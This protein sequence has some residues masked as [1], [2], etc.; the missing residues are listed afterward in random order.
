MARRRMLDPNF[1]D[2]EDVCSLPDTER[3][4]LVCCISNADDEGKLSGSAATIK[5]IAFG[6]TDTTIQEV[7]QMLQHISKVIR[8]FCR[9]EVE[10]KTYIK[11]LHWSKYQRVD[12][13]YAS[14]IPDPNESNSKNDSE[15]DSE[16][17]SENGSKNQTH[18]LINKVI[19]NELSN[20]GETQAKIVMLPTDFELWY[21]AYP[22]KVAKEAASKA[23][24]KQKKIMPTL[25][26]MLKALDRQKLS[27]EWLNNGGKFIPYPATYLN[28]GRWADEVQ[29]ANIE[30]PD[31]MPGGKNRPRI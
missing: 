22:K 28:Q 16:N 12:H 31:N 23:W 3:L 21:Q 8:G 7:E 4:L 26:D 14:V 20:E 25:G 27:T 29:T 11:L 19:S 6:M 5:K 17:G 1:W 13:P 9:Y 24:S 30:I 10:G 2:D 15:N 18:Q